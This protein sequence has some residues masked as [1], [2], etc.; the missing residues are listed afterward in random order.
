MTAPTNSEYLPGLIINEGY[1]KKIDLVNYIARM[2][3][4]MPPLYEK[5]LSRVAGNSEYKI[6]EF[7]SKN[8]I[9]PYIIDVLELM[10][11]TFVEIYGFVPLT[12]KE[13]LE[14]AGRYLPILDPNFIKIVIAKEQV[15]GF[16]IGMPLE[17]LLIVK[18]LEL[19]DSKLS[20][21]TEHLTEGFPEFE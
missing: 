14:F 4:K 21:V 13:K 17:V 1:D 3:E 8:E 5:I 7:T 12:E 10:N 9:K 20:E 16:A 6:I 19:N 18:V 15:I 11:E 2:P